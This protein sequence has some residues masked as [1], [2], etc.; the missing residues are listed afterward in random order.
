MKSILPTEI[1]SFSNMVFDCLTKVS[2][3]KKV[4]L[5]YFAKARFY[6]LHLSVED[7]WKLSG[8]FCCLHS[9]LYFSWIWSE[10]P[11]LIW[12]DSLCYR[13]CGISCFGH[14]H[15]SFAFQVLG[16]IWTSLLLFWKYSC[17]MYHQVIKF[18]SQE[19]LLLL[20]S[21]IGVKLTWTLKLKPALGFE[22]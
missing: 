10:L 2:S 12:T 22:D 9:G 3:E 21:F 14:F 5:G 15:F 7:F 13:F 16:S 17:V 1:Q 18:C 8:I 19:F 11:E 6:Y 4:A 20:W